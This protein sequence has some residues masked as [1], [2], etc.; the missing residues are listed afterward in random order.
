MDRAKIYYQM[1]Q[2]ELKHA[3]NLHNIAIQEIN[4]LKEAIEPPESML[5]K[6]RYAHGYFIEKAA[7]IKQMLSL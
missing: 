2:D 5:D 6:W 4:A 3:D 7:W 1:A